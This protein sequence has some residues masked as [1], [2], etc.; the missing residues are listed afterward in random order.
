MIMY[1]FEKTAKIDE[2]RVN[3]YNILNVYTYD[4]C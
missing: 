3:Q 2:N 1:A 4:G